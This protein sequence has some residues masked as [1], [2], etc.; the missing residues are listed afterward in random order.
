MSTDRNHKK[1][2][3]QNSGSEEYNN[4]IENFTRGVQQNT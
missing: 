4:Y 2:T 1:E 3:N